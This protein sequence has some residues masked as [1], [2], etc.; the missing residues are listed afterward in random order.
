[1]S[2]AGGGANACC[3]SRTV[4]L[5]KFP[6]EIY[7]PFKNST[8]MS[9]DWSSSNSQRHPAGGRPWGWRGV[10]KRSFYKDADSKRDPCAGAARL[11]PEPLVQ[12]ITF[13]S[14]I[15]YFT[16]IK[17]ALQ[18]SILPLRYQSST[19]DARRLHFQVRNVTECF[20]SAI[21]T[22]LINWVIQFFLVIQKN[23]ENSYTFQELLLTD[24]QSSRKIFILSRMIFLEHERS[25]KLA[26]QTL[27]RQ[28]RS[29]RRIY[30]RKFFSQIK[31]SAD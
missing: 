15:V 19:F 11:L 5:H 24:V 8:A 1:M 26:D 16:P 29:A 14:V 13:S 18:R 20:P 6:L 2:A 17:K 28:F 27:T 10:E 30:W 25:S 23:I 9:H 7:V 31:T 4:Q 12:I 21:V 22:R 3:S